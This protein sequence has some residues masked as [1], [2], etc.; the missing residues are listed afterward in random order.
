MLKAMFN[1]AAF[2]GELRLSGV[3]S[4]NWARIVPQV[5]YYVTSAL[6]LGGPDVPVS[7]S[8]PS[9]NFGDVFAGVRRAADGAPGGPAH[10]REQRERHPHPSPDHRRPPAHRGDPDPV[11]FDGHPGLEQLRAVAVRDARPRRRVHRGADAPAR[12]APRVP[13]RRRR[14]RGGSVAVPRGPLHRSGDA[15]D[16]RRGAPRHRHGHRSAHRGR[17]GGRGT[18][19]R[20]ARDPDDHP[21]HRP[22]GQVPPTRSSAR[23]A[24]GPPYPGASPTST[25]AKSAAPRCRTT[26]RR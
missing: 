18:N 12:R 25:S 11:A 1:D 2:R 4:I 3:N 5:V 14:R 8:V 15:G 22:S 21:R 9:G 19:A 16:H 24:S 17:G 7:F 23:S 10:C 6:A 13:D 20:R 26:C